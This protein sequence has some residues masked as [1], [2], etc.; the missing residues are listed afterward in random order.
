M[1][2][3]DLNKVIY[4][5]QDFQTAVD[6]VK[7]FLNT[8]YPDEYNDYVATNLG[9]ALIDIIAYGEQN[10][11]WYLNRK[12]T[13]LY[14]P[15]AVTPNSVSKISRMLG[16]KA[17]GATAAE[18]SV[19]MT[20]T[21]GPYTFP[22]TVA[23]G[24][25][26]KG[27]SNTV[28]EYR[29]TVPVVYAPGETVKTFNIGQGTTVVSTFIS[30]GAN[31]QFFELL[32]VPPGKF[33]AGDSVVVKV[34]GTDWDEYDAIP[35]LNV[36][37][38][39]TNIVAS[40]PFVKFGD[41]VQGNVPTTGAGIEV[42]FVVTDGFKGRI[43]REAITAPL[44]PLVANF[45]QIPVSINQPA[46]SVGGDDPED[47]RSITVN[48]PVFQRTQDRAITKGDYDFLSNQYVN[49]AKADA[50]IVRSISGD[51]LANF[52]F[53]SILMAVSGYDQGAY[54]AIVGLTASVSGRI[55][56]MLTSVSGQI[57]TLKSSINFDMAAIQGKTED[58]DD[59]M[60]SLLQDIAAVCD[61]RA[62]SIVSLTQS[63]I[64]AV[65]ACP[66]PVQTTVSSLL[67]SI[68][69]NVNGL[70]GEAQA[71]TTTTLNT[72]GLLTGN[73]DTSAADTLADVAA[74]QGLVDAS[75]SGAR[76][77]A[78]DELKQIRTTAYI[79]Y[80]SVYDEVKFY[81]D[82]VSGH[83]DE[84]FTSG[85]DGNLVEIRVLGKDANRKYVDPLQTTLD[86]LK[87]Y[88]NARKEITQ[89]LSVITGTSRVI[90]ADIK[91]QLRAAQTAIED[92]VVAAIEE[93]LIKS[94]VEPFGLLV[95]RAFNESLFKWDVHEAIRAN[96]VPLDQIDYLNIDIT[97]PAQYL[98][99]KGNLIAP[100]GFV[101]QAGTLTIERLARF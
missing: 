2:V 50:Q 42:T 19:T 88:L 35:F 53:D 51:T 73:I 69:N 71:A 41:S 45:I 17:K 22:V 5:D 4:A 49:V 77:A 62:A 15:S 13:D 3:D 24:F 85:C 79:E 29:G 34:A 52:Y 94:D 78:A 82:A 12:V 87:A 25:R 54:T 9:Q 23:K 39:E 1:A 11:A 40:P 27:P 30:N 20:L 70:K 92:D 28:W 47:L 60:A 38:Y 98:D 26:F 31:N 61:D 32:A 72:V 93:A 6:A 48:A 100:E 90:S 89:T 99:A 7:N 55:D 81:V 97:G 63:V 101:I 16:Y 64:D 84:H 56:S 91:I 83:L 33:V 65:S 96:V 8:N 66:L 10:L 46:G 37:A 59:A 21:K 57:T 74:F 67:S 80:G 68:N 44:I 75:V 18:T 43:T 36:N 95:E 58:I 76:L 14:F 86:G